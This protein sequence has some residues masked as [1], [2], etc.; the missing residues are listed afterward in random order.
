MEYNLN[1][2]QSVASYL[3]EKNKQ[4]KIWCFYGEMGV[5]KTTLIKEILAQLGVLDLVSSPS[6]S[7]VN[8]YQITGGQS[9]FHFDFYRIRSLEEVYDL[10]FETYFDSGSLCLIEWPE[11]IDEI[12]QMEQHLKIFLTFG[13]GKR[14]LT[15][16]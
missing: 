10:G 2:L 11:K 9:V 5:G 16:V 15:L 6:F 1:E 13:V 7:I 14:K 12:L 8:E 4:H 3:L